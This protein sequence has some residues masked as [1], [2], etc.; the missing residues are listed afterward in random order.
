MKNKVHVVSQGGKWALTNSAG[1]ETVT[2]VYSTKSEALSAARSSP[3]TSKVVVH[4]STGQII[5][6]PDVKTTRDEKVMRTAVANA[7]QRSAKAR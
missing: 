7:V 2:G 1:R 5:R 3:R 6:T 4:T